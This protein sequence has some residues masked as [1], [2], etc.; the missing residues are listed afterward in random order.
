MEEHGQGWQ[1]ACHH[2]AAVAVVDGRRS[3]GI[4]LGMALVAFQQAVAVAGKWRH[5]GGR[6]WQRK[7]N[8]KAS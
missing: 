7:A 6:C 3:M 4:T 5:S 1:W 2:Q 8:K